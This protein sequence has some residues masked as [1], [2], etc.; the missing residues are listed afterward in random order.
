M[1]TLAILAKDVGNHPALLQAG[2]ATALADALRALGHAEDDAPVRVNLLRVLADLAKSSRADG[3]FRKANVADVL[4][5]TLKNHPPPLHGPG[6]VDWGLS[7]FGWG[8][9]EAKD[10]A[11]AGAAGS[12]EDTIVD[13]LTDLSGPL[14]AV[15]LGAGIAYHAVRCASNLAKNS[16]T[17]EEL[18]NAGLL[19]L[20]CD[21]L[22]NANVSHFAEEDP[23]LAELVRCT[24]LAVAALAK[25]APGDVV[26]RGGHK[27]LLHFMK[28]GDDPVA[29]MYAAG[30][31]RNLA[32]HGDETEANWRVHR[33][34]VVAGA[35]DALSAGMKK[36]AG[37]QTRTFAALAFGDLMTTG[38]Y[39]ADII[40]RRLEPAFASF[41][42]LLR[43]KN[44]GLTRT[45]YRT[46]SALFGE[47]EASRNV[48]RRNVVAPPALCKLLAKESG[49]VVNGAAARGD[50]TALKALRAMC[51]DPVVAQGMVDKGLLE[52]LV[53][54]ASKGKGEYWEESVAALSILSGWEKF[55]PLMVSRGALRAVL[56][57]PCLEHDGRWTA[58]FFANMA[59]SEEHH[60]E[61]ARGGLKVLLMALGSKDES[62]KYEGAR[63]LYNLS[64]G[65][66]SRVMMAQGGT[67]SPLA[68]TAGSTTDDTRRFAVGAL[69]K[70]AEGPDH[71]IKLIEAD[72]VSVMLKA[73]NEDSKVV[74]DVAISMA[75]M[76]CVREVHGYLA[77]SG[78]AAWLVDMLSKSGGRERD[79]THVMH[80]AAL[81]ICNLSYSAGITRT[82]LLEN[83]AMRILTAISASGMGLPQVVFTAKQALR[84]LKG[85][86]KPNM[87]QVQRMDQPLP[88]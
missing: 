10:G 75:N 14:P 30:G 87:M 65:G 47:T 34:L 59:R 16:A 49:Q 83:G 13:Y 51:V 44:P 79:A 9:D 76:S 81:G 69:A 84:N 68:K 40:R 12:T 53:R 86:D 26:A 70:I 58:A 77:R 2:A 50:V 27:R 46:L 35:V 88:A 20:L 41:A 85:N 74:K 54:G 32:R 24:I 18:L 25:S 66:I 21:A 43:E 82:V 42:A 57:R 22:R 72:V 67:L 36:E 80:Y 63:G 8:G 5:T 56:A 28:E 33:E 7:L 52:V 64:L 6:W 48:G 1:Q 62:S 78:A 71:V 11:A 31:V 19:P 15:D 3:Y 37:A 45:V 60:M 38:H 4:A 55:A 39:K 73:A 23:Q 29:Q 17:H 61:I